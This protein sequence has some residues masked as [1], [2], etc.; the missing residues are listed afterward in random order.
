MYALDTNILVRYIMQDDAE[1]AKLASDVIEALTTDKQAFISC[2]VLCEVNWVLK[3]AYGISKQECLNTLNK[4]ITVAVFDI[5]HI[6]CCLHALKAWQK[7]NADFSDYLIQAIAEAKG[8]KKTLSFDKKALKSDGFE[9][10][11][12]T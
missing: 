5:E 9:C 3:S 12:T 4:I 6:D 1:Q 7:G 10:P 8:Y 11:Y 2:I